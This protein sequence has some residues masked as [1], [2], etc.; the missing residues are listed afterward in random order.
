MSAVQVNQLLGIDLAEGW[1]EFGFEGEKMGW[2]VA[3][4]AV[5][6]V[7]RIFCEIVVASLS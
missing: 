7:R 5:A 6:A 4:A 3:E 1:E 2:K